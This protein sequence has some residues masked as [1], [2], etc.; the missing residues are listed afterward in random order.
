DI[1][2]GVGL[3]RLGH[4]PR[5][6][7]VK[8]LAGELCDIGGIDSLRIIGDENGTVRRVAI[9][10]GAGA[11]LW[12]PAVARGADLL[13][14]GDVD[15]HT[16]E[17]MAAAGLVVIDM[18]HASSEAPFLDDFAAA[19][20]SELEDAGRSCDV[21]EMEPKTDPWGTFCL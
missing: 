5:A 9:S 11:D 18:G 6:T 2:P 16:A 7:R 19:L 14:T 13:I 8:D 21:I 17:D 20:G 10:S 12:E 15:Y 3:G 4:L 1:S